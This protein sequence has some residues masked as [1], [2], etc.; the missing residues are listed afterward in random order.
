MEEQIISNQVE[1]SEKRVSQIYGSTNTFFLVNGTTSGI[2]AAVFATT[3]EG[4]TVLVSR[5]CCKSV[6][7]A[8]ELHHLKARM[9]ELDRISQFD[10]DGALNSV[11]IDS[12]L[13]ESD[14]E[15]A[16]AVIISSITSLGVVSDV[17]AISS[18]CKRHGIPL[19]VD[20][21]KG[22]HFSLDD[23]VPLSAI[24][25]GADIV[26]HEVS[27]TMA[28]IEQAG[29]L[30]VKEKMVDINHIKRY[31]QVFEATKPSQAIYQSIV[32]V[33]DDYKEQG[34][35]RWDDYFSYRMEFLLRMGMLEHL[36]TLS[37]DDLA[38]YPGIEALD[39]A[40]IV[41]TTSN[42][43]IDSFE[44]CKRLEDNYNI[45]SEVV[46]DNCVVVIFSYSDT[47]E[48]WDQLAQSLIEIDASVGRPTGIKWE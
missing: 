45:R 26:I 13:S 25:N 4:D 7:D 32:D 2:L 43:D 39:P 41:I 34:V 19:I 15:P 36:K 3:K 17:R 28:T 42:S 37:I 6:F 5:N 29:L 18:V 48:K 23:R 20:E 27:G 10:I 11:D 38:G 47:M 14:K 8:I 1:I 30:H 46:G 9:I 31:L 12:M 44:L 40:K 33:F 21:S 16:T 22:I 24:N 35:R